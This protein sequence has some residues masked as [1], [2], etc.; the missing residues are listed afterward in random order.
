MA[1]DPT[2]PAPQRKQDRGRMSR[3][4]LLAAGSAGLAGLAM[5][6]IVRAE[7][8][9]LYV[10]SQGGSWEAAAQKNLFKP[11]TEETGIEIRTSTGQTFATLAL[12]TRSGVYNYDIATVGAPSV[13]Q[14]MSA[15]LLEPVNFDLFDRTAVPADLVYENAVGNH[16]YST[17]IAFNT[18]KNPAGSIKTWIDFWDTKAH[19]GSRS[20]GRTLEQTIVFTLLADGVPRDQL[21]PIDLDRVFKS[22]DRIKPA[23]R[24]W[25]TTGPQIRQLLGD[26][27]VDAASVWHAHAVALRDGGAPI[28][29]VWN[30]FTMD[31]TFWIIS[32]GTPRSD[33]AWKFVNFALRPKNNAGFCIDGNY[34]PLNPKAFDFIKPEQAKNMPTNAAYAG[35]AIAYRPREMGQ[36]LIDAQR[37]FERWLQA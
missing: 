4:G 20:L 24:V 19:P 22:L 12:Q 14:A 17:N 9:V 13:V 21:Y 36:A 18:Q 10:N 26:D 27:E 6:S 32:R 11:F 28:E 23:V 2:D 31:R 5:P 35:G 34:G 3:R 7:E 25:W 15:N 30:E 33:N 16:A 29:I 37:R 8:K 1:P